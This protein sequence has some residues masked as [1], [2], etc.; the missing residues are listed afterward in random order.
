[1]SMDKK[2]IVMIV[3]WFMVF[4][5]MVFFLISMI[6][7]MNF[8]SILHIFEVL[9]AIFYIGASLYYLNKRILGGLK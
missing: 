2:N 8:D 5:G 3:I 1:M 9:F 7:I 4:F 6:P